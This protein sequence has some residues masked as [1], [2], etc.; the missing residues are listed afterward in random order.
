MGAR[1]RRVFETSER[2][3]GLVLS[4]IRLRV[5]EKLRWV[6]ILPES[7][8]YLVLDVEKARDQT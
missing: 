2:Q 1:S 8:L 7:G 3:K 6:G 4:E 5:L